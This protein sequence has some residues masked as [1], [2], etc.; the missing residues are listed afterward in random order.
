MSAPIRDEQ[1]LKP[2][3]FC[4][5]TDAIVRHQPEIDEWVVRCSQG[6][7]PMAEHDA[8]VYAKSRAAAIRAW[9]TRGGE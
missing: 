1:K 6:M 8:T 9:N 3:P 4:G 2:C 7:R 5:R